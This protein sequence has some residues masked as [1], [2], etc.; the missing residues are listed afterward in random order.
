MVC[1]ETDLILNAAMCLT[2]LP[3]G[4]KLAGLPLPHWRT[5]VASSVLGGLAALV[6]ALLPALTPL[7]LL[8]LP[9]A[10]LICFR[11]HGL[12]ACLRCGVTTLG[13]S[14]LTGGAATALVGGGMRPLPAVSLSA[15]VS[16]LC[17][18][19]VTLLPAA[20]CDVRQVELR[21]GEN[22][23]LL[24][25]MLDSGNL[26]RDPVTGTPVLVVPCKAASAL[27]PEVPDLCDL[28]GLPLG[29]RLLSVHT[30]AGSSLL[31][32]FRP[33]LCRLYL[34]GNACD[35]DLLVAIAGREYG[36]VQALVPMAALPRQSAQP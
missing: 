8:S 19:L 35:A 21:V 31:P 28:R 29:F 15:C 14:F 23:V 4:G 5:L 3:L 25:A 30:A 9:I 27:F 12:P 22:A 32:L 36:G 6:A 26:L 10:V 2:A 20:L 11:S 17:Y 33:D 7:M 18:L 24:P 13:A 34:N 1:A 16:W